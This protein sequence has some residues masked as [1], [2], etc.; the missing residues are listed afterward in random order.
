MPSPSPWRAIDPFAPEA[1]QRE[2]VV[3]G[4]DCH[5]VSG[6][7]LAA[8]EKKSRCV[9]YLSTSVSDG[10]G[11][12][13]LFTECFVILLQINPLLLTTPPSWSKY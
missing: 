5:T 4:Q 6:C 7:R 9:G 12:I 10:G 11:D 1:T 13:F 8:H 2:V 3:P